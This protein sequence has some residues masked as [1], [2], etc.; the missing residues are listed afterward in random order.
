M[1]ATWMVLLYGDE[2]FWA[3]ASQEVQD[4]VMEEHG[5]YATAC[6]ERGYKIIGGEELGLSN[7]AITARRPDG[8]PV[9]ISD[10]PYIE[11]AE[12]LGGYYL[13]ETDDPQGLARL[14]GELL[15]TDGGGVELRPVILHP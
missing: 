11:T 5:A 3:T 8:G 10:G 1:T 7:T 14:T 9:A 2:E 13:V 12:H 15:L 4:R 6:A